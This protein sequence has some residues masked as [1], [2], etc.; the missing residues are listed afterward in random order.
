MK[1]DAPTFGM[2]TLTSSGIGGQILK[3]RANI[4][5]QTCFLA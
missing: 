3:W 4:G 1:Y 2:S 5:P